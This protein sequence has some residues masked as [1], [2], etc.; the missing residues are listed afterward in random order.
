MT[1]M[2]CM[3]R[4]VWFETLVL[5]IFVTKGWDVAQAVEHSPVTVGIIRLQL[6]FGLFSI[7]TS[8]Q[9]LVHQRLWYVLGTPLT[10]AGKMPIMQGNVV[11]L[12][13]SGFLLFVGVLHLIAFKAISRCIPIVTVH[14]LIL[15]S[16]A[17][18]KR[19]NCWHHDLISHSTI[20]SWY[21][22]KD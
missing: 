18:L 20:F 8:G 13:A 19:P 7:S 1:R 11:S 4:P 14:S 15:Y 6:Q 3:P 17:Q 12:F 22:G 16:T 5:C 21:R 10:L 2:L 9:Q